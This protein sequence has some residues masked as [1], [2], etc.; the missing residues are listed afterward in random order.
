MKTILTKQGLEILKSKL[1]I[2]IE[3]LKALREEKAH[4]YTASGDGWHDN[5]GWTQLGQ[6]E[7][8]LAK[9]VFSLQEKISSA[10]V[11]ENSKIDPN[12]VNIGCLVEYQMVRNNI[13]SKQTLN[14]VGNCES[15]IRNKRISVESPMGKALFN[16]K[17]GEEKELQLPAGSFKI[18]IESINYE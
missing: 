3:E 5:P 13:I 17:I 4:A 10:I 9:D 14:I 2:K 11:V 12:R 15:D 16:M 18:K 8:I 6:Q 7:E 1:S